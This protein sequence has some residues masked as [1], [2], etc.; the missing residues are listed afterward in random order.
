MYIYIKFISI[1]FN[2]K[3]H[4]IVKLKQNALYLILQWFLVYTCYKDNF[5]PLQLKMR[6]PNFQ[7][8]YSEETILNLNPLLYLYAL[9]FIITLDNDNHEVIH[10]RKRRWA[11]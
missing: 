3:S 2:K 8:R 4:K 6:W 5:L 9:I 10:S 1:S 7:T 11:Q